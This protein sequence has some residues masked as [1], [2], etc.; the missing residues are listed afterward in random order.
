M[1]AENIKI[2]FS[3]ISEDTK[4]ILVRKNRDQLSRVIAGLNEYITAHKITLDS[5]TPPIDKIFAAFAHCDINKVNVVIIAQDPYPGQGHANGLCFAVNRGITI[6]PSLKNIYNC[7][8]HCGEI[9]EMPTHG[10]LTSWAKQGVLMINAALTTVIGQSNEHAS[11]WSEYTDTIIADIS[12][13]QRPIIFILLGGFAQKKSKLID[14]RHTKLEWGHPSPTNQANKTDNPKNFKYCDVFSKC[15]TALKL[16]GKPAINWDPDYEIVEAVKSVIN[17]EPVNAP[18][19]L[20]KITPREL[21]ETDPIPEVINTLWVFTDGGSSGN[22][23]SHCSATWA[24]YATD[25]LL[26][27]E[28]YGSVAKVN[29]PN[30]VYSTSNQRAELTAIIYAMEFLS[31]DISDFSHEKISIISDSSYAIN[32]INNWAAQWIINENLDHKNIDL[33]LPAHHTWKKLCNKYS[34]RIQ[35]HHISERN[36]KSHDKIENISNDPHTIFWWKGNN[37]ADQL[38]KKAI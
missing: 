12:A 37:M 15:N 13:L 18:I 8:L 26:C 30:Q 35:F 16:F 4:T 36:I 38:C 6:P 3:Q 23:K 20:P 25:G 1:N 31:G 19:V 9:K 7:L 17:I 24:F 11:I 28:A 33:I 21:S 14:N 32:C 2:A 22:G 27:A 34:S 29:I 5:I 10:D